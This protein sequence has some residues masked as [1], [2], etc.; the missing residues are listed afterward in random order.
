[1]FTNIS[2]GAV[3][4][5]NSNMT[6]GIGL[7]WQNRIRKAS[8]LFV[9]IQK[10]KG[11]SPKMIFTGGRGE[12]LNSYLFG[13]Q[14]H[15]LPKEV[16]FEEIESGTTLENAKFG[17]TLLFSIANIPSRDEVIITVVSDTYHVFRCKIFFEKYFGKGNVLI[18]SS[19]SDPLNRIHGTIRELGAVVKKF[20][21]W[22]FELGSS[23]GSS[24]K[25]I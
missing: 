22:S 13:Q 6:C 16:C 4:D 14:K 24:H 23:Y 9:H 7:P 2:E 21:C 19:V 3:K 12:A 1:L 20:A 15:G 17:H 18:L 8:D 11:Y 25:L 5:I 10:S